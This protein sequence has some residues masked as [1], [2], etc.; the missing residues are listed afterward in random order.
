MTLNSDKEKFRKMLTEIESEML[1][2][3]HEV[4]AISDREQRS[5]AMDDY[6]MWRM[7]KQTLLLSEFKKWVWSD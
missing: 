6:I 7:Q 5:K 4:N 1:E 3:L 2:R